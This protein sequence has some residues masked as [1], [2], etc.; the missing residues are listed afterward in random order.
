MTRKMK[1]SGIE[2]IGDIPME[3]KFSKIKFDCYLKGR[4]GWQGLTSN[5]Y[6]EEGPFLITGTDFKNGKINWSSCV[7]ITKERFN[8]APEIH[9]KEND[10][11]ITKDGTV[12][13]VAIAELAPEKVSLNSGVLLIRNLNNRYYDKYMYYILVSELFWSWF[14]SNLAGNSTI[15]HLYQEKFKEFSYPLP[16]VLEQNKIAN[17]LDKKVSLMD[18]SIEMHKR[19][20]GELKE[21]KQSIITE[22]VTKGLNPNVPMKDSGIEWIGVIPEHWKMVKIKTI[23]SSIDERN[24]EDENA[25]LLSLFTAIGVKPRSEMEDKGNKAATVINYKKVQK[26]DLIVNKLLAWMG[27]VA[28]SDYEGVTSPDYDVYRIK[29]GA[30]AIKDYY[31]CYFRYTNFKDDC[32]KYGHGIM[33]MRWRTYPNEFLNIFIANPPIEEQHQIAKYIMKK[34]I[35]IDNLIK[36]KEQLIEKLESY[37]KSLIY[38]CVTGKREV[39]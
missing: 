6:V 28:F 39:Q 3:W 15:L 5:E 10:L 32:Y 7:H 19:L 33:M 16:S 26:E 29:K 36:V 23:F 35:K 31:N 30:N 37:K 24:L 11:L 14:N 13:K 38:E 18:Q 4:I 2:W 12:G 27:A 1:D 8:E 20:I 22:A 9:I 21:Y 25:V 34:N 17:Y